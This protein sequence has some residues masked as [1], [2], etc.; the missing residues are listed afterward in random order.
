MSMKEIIEK[1]GGKENV[2]VPKRSL[3]EDVPEKGS[4]AIII[5]HKTP[6]ALLPDLPITIIRLGVVDKLI[7]EDPADMLSVNIIDII[8]LIKDSDGSIKNIK[9][10]SVKSAKT[11]LIK[12]VYPC[13]IFRT[14]K[15][16]PFAEVKRTVLSPNQKDSNIEFAQ[17][18]WDMSCHNQNITLFTSGGAEVTIPTFDLEADEAEE[19]F[20]I[21]WYI[22][23]FTENMIETGLTSVGIAEAFT[24]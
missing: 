17:T 21:N 3:V 11:P 18:G 6:S 24:L 20:D 8:K 23:C 14:E 9:G 13:K 5:G 10:V 12:R 7:A 19:G 22:L 16:V 1:A 15:S 4:F 2:A